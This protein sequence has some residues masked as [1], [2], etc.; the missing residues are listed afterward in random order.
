MYQSRFPDEDVST[1]TMQQLRGREGTRVR[2]VY[3]S[4]SEK[5]QVSWTKR[6]YNPDDFEGGDI[7][8]QALSAANVALYGLVHSIVVAL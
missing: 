5:Y 4:Q 6:A 3:R 7:V 1:M 2:R 8:N